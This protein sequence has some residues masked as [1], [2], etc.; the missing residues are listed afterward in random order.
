M[1]K[2]NNE[3]VNSETTEYG[4][5][6]HGEKLCK[7]PSE[8]SEDGLLCVG[9]VESQKLKVERREGTFL[10]VDLLR[11]GAR[12]LGVEL[13]DDQ[14]ELLDRFAWL[15]VETNRT[16]N[17]TRI[18]EPREIVTG[19]YLDSFT[20]L[21][22]TKIKPGSRVID[23]GAG[24]GFPGIPIKIA[25]PDLSMTLLDSSAKKLKFIEDAVALLSD[26]RG[27]AFAKRSDDTTGYVANAS[28]LQVTLVHARAEEAGRDPAHREAYDVAFA[29]ALA[30]MKTLAELCLPL[31]KVGGALIAQKSEGADEEIEAARAIVGQLG[32]RIDKIA[33]IKIPNTD[34]TRWLVVVSKVKPTPPEF[35]RPYSRIAK[36]RGK[37]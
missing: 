27:E 12:E 11:D 35:P 21:A 15:V 9:E 30:D 4:L 2:L 31:V 18:T 25:R 20:C 26:C 14:I 19:H 29:R 3:E 23:V 24:A 28:P 16:L 8:G 10:P 1:D 22:A 6:G 33:R 17:L 13:K 37:T 7:P 36:K 34:I 5:T 32:G